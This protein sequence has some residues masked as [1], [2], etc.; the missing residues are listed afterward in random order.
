MTLEDFFKQ[1]QDFGTSMNLNVDEMYSNTSLQFKINQNQNYKP[2]FV[3][4]GIE[5]DNKDCYIIFIAFYQRE[6]NQVQ[7]MNCAQEL[8]LC[9]LDEVG[10][11]LCKQ[12]ILDGIKVRKEEKNQYRLN[13]INKDF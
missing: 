6:K 5:L 9:T 13:D 8:R 7:Y 10:L 3:K 2:D 12:S 11:E 4:N 1:L